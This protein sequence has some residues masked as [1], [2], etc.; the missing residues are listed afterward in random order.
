MSRA[1]VRPGAF[2]CPVRRPPAFSGRGRQT[3]QAAVYGLFVIVGSVVALFFLFN[4]GQLSGEK[5]KLVNTGDAVAYSAGVMNA[6]TLNYQAYANRAMLANTVA[7]AQLVS[8]SSWVAHVETLGQEYGG[9]R[10]VNW[11]KYPTYY[12]SYL[13]AQ[14]AGEYLAMLNEDRFGGSPLEALASAS[15]GIIRSRL[16]TA[17]QVAHAGLI[18]ARR[19]VM[20]EVAQAN[21]RDDG[22][23]TVEQLILGVD[24]PGFVTRYAGD[25]RTRFAEAAKVAAKLDD[26]V[27]KRS[28]TIPALYPQG[29]PY[30]FDWLSRRGGTELIGF[31]EW[32][33]L[34][35]LSEW[36]WKM[37]KSGNC[38]LSE[39]ALGYGARTAA[40]Q[41]D[42]DTDFRRY[43]YAR[44]TN[45]FASLLALSTASSDAWDYSGLPNFYDLSESRLEED[46]PALRF[47]VRIRRPV[48][49]TRTSE[50]RAAVRGSGADN[51]IAQSLNN[52]QAAPA[53]GDELVAVSASEAFFE[54]TG[55]NVYGQKLGKPRELASLFNPFWQVRLV[56]ADDEARFAQGQQGAVLP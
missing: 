14:T 44:I 12:P 9:G 39:N 15:D 36:R 29:C 23:V 56:S 48:G 33:A 50:G 45:P 18:P 42:A 31:D 47:S 32:K 37:S 40:D 51:R 43:D 53:G 28:W 1:G 5:T 6:R 26:F 52:F 4:T 35:T 17:Q 34:D 13:V 2:R 20:E 3:G 46:D 22:S 49:Q 54:R 16:M 21:Y 24:M 27:P 10:W 30:A 41:P 8:L 38:Y 55:D 25:E 7:I 11:S 19:R